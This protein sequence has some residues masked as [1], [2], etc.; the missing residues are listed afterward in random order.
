MEIALLIYGVVFCCAWVAIYAYLMRSVTTLTLFHQQT[1]TE[2]KQWPRLSVIVPACNEAEHIEAAA[3]S[4]IEQ[5]YPDLEIIL[6]NDRSKDNTGEIIERLAATNPQVKTVHI[7]TL[8]DNWLGK[9]HALHQGQQ[10]A[11]GEWLLFTDA[12]IHFVPRV[13]RRAV[14][15]VRE[16]HVDHLALLPRVILNSFWLQV[17]IR[18][19]GLLFFLTTRA[20]SINQP[21]SKAVIGI[22]AFN[23][24]K[25]E[26]F[27][28]TP[29]FEWLRME[30]VDDM[31][32]G[33][34]VSNAGGKT[35]FALA[36]NDLSVTWYASIIAM[37]RG[38]EKNLFGPG[39]NYRVSKMLAQVGLIW[40]L[41]AAPFVS[42]FSTNPWL[43]G[44][45]VLVIVMYLIFSV[46]FVRE[47]Q[48]ETL[49]LLLFPL[50]LLL[51]SVMMLWAGFQ[52]V[53]NNGVDWR[54]THYSL[55]QLRA[56]QRVKL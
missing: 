36:D 14:S 25:R 19:F 33:L 13:L 46:F 40:A 50:G 39:A 12:D 29:G 20:P 38:L 51:L 32:V 11:S 31:G 3:K 34:L 8:P 1:F 37:F 42:L 23:L 9:V 16:H 49:S 53:K 27:A 30:P 4:L 17:A 41:V 43:I 6:V 54:G 48:S 52:C 7:E 2:P 45:A 28:K 26:I 18:T 10:V 55:E 35:H 56:G 15:Y 44:A 24:V 21:E 5:D 47:K 22:G